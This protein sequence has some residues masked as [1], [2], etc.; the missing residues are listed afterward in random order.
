MDEALA[1]LHKHGISRAMIHAGGDMRFGDPPPE[2]SGWVVGIAPRE[3]NGPPKFYLS[4]SRCAVATSGDMWQYVE[5]GSK[6]YSHIVDP[7]TGL[8]LTDRS[9]VAVV[10]HDGMTADGLSTAVSVLGLAKG[11]K[12]VE[13]TPGAAM[14]IIHLAD[15][16]EE[17]HQSSRW[18]DLRVVAAPTEK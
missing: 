14:Y 10:A 15:G 16:K 13:Q 11:L 18:K 9:T 5:L 7:K 17:T 4:V 8:G 2:K 12:L 1:V 6:R 3:P